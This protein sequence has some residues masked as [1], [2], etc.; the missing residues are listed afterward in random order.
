MLVQDG[1]PDALVQALSVHRD[2]HLAEVLRARLLN[3]PCVVLALFSA[4]HVHQFFDIFT[5]VEVGSD[6]LC[7]EALV[8]DQAVIVL[9]ESVHVDAHEAKELRVDELLATQDANLVRKD[10]P[11]VHIHLF[12]FF[13]QREKHLRL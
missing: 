8:E 12:W 11:E 10:L 3:V 1:E 9:V 4:P 2:A 7:R 13:I 6:Q 5:L